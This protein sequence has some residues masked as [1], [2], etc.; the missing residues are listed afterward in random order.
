MRMRVKMAV[1][2][3]LDYR[4]AACSAIVV[5]TDSLRFS[6]NVIPECD[7]LG[8]S[9]R[10]KLALLKGSTEKKNLTL[11][12]GCSCLIHLSPLDQGQGE[13]KT[14]WKRYTFWPCWI[15]KTCSFYRKTSL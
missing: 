3:F 6:I 4:K 5:T 2:N 10:E 13:E 9:E 11:S 12:D 1:N 8:E 7:R 15:E 14:S